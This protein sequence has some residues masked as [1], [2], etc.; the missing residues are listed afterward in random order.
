MFF[1]VIFKKVTVTIR[2]LSYFFRSRSR[3]LNLPGAGAG[4]SKRDRLRQ[5]CSNFFPKNFLAFKVTRPAKNRRLPS[6]FCAYHW[7]H[8]L[9][10]LLPGIG[11]PVGEGLSYL[12]G[13]R[14]G[15]AHRL[16]PHVRIFARVNPKQKEA[17]ITTLKYLGRFVVGQFF[18]D[19][20]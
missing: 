4:K 17:V 8:S 15:L 6:S 16:L 10:N 9:F 7:T 19:S 14:A 11:T 18:P 2:I 5:R 3:F 1:N 13:E 20:I 12:V